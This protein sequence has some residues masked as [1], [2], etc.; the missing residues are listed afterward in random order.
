MKASGYDGNVCKDL[1]AQFIWSAFE[2]IKCDE[3]VLYGPVMWW[4]SNHIA[5]KKFLTGHICNR[6]DFN[7]NSNS[8]ILLAHW[9]NKNEV[10]HSLTCNTDE[11]NICYDI[12][13]KTPLLVIY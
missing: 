4:K 1:L 3:Y 13:K 9:L 6:K 11:I 10:N 12:K 2:I 5:D 8:G 7:T